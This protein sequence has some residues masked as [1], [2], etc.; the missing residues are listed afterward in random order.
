MIGRKP[1]GDARRPPDKTNRDKGSSG[2]NG[3]PSPLEKLRAEE[4][5]RERFAAE[6]K[7]RE[8]ETP[9]EDSR[10]D[11]DATTTKPLTRPR[12]FLEV[13]I[14][15]RPRYGSSEG[16]LEKK[17]RIEFELFVEAVPR[18]V[19][20]FR[21][22]CTGED[23]ANL[24]FRDSVFHRIIPG[25][26][27]QGGDITDGDGTGGHSIYGKQF[28]DEN[29]SKRHDSAGVLSM[30]NCGPNSNNSQFF[31]CFKATPHLDGKH[32]VFG[33]LVSDSAGLLRR[34][35][36]SGSESGEPKKSVRI[37]D[38]GEI[39]S[40]TDVSKGSRS[41]SRSKSPTSRERRRRSKSRSRS[42]RSSRS[43]S[44]RRRR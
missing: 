36:A 10:A 35:E 26:M 23:G 12:V 13:E 20:N 32:V 43:R 39:K 9:E 8:Q 2:S 25:F 17:G 5:E 21:R 33:K 30:A 18:T 42:H 41:K 19:E 24:H 27:A 4:A 31:L 3:G 14:R 15:Q 7:T 29:F 38:C 44:R 16:D 34:I 1:R 28:A 11:R 37:V 22:L 40:K 6:Y